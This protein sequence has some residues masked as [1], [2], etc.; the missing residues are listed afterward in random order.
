MGSTLLIFDGTEFVP[1]TQQNAPSQ[2]EMTI[3]LTHGWVR[4]P[5]CDVNTGIAG[6]PTDMAKTLRASGVTPEQ[7]NIVGWELCATNS[8]SWT[9]PWHNGKRGRR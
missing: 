9:Q 4:D 1:I 6:W 3:V 7:A 2:D 5:V 8:F